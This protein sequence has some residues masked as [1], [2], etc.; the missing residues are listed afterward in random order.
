MK[1]EN[2]T[3]RNGQKVANQFLIIDQAN[4]IEYFQ[5]YNSIIVKSEI[6]TGKITLDAKY[7]N[8]STT[9]SKYRNLFLAQTTTE[10]E[11]KIK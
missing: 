11:Q 1:V 2:L 7:W 6:L 10:I 8:Y 5:S 4:K 3:N 9:T